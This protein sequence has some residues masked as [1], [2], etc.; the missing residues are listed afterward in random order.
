MGSWDCEVMNE[1]PHHPVLTDEDLMYSAT[2][3]CRCGSGLAYPL[4]HVRARDQG[5]WICAVFLK[6][7]VAHGEHD[8]LPFAFYKIREETS[9]N[10]TGGYTTRP[11]GTMA[12]TIGKAKCPKCN[13]EWKS[14]PYSA[15]GTS[16]HWFSGA[17]PECGYDVGGHRVYRS[18]DGDRIETRYYT[19]VIKS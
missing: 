3:R 16:H 2:V 17:C 8:I 13:C 7:D 18:G 12:R 4:D 1:Q 6:C 5:A 15:C 11:S 19:V 14:D 10:N 9:I